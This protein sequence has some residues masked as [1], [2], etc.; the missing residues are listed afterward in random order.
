[1]SSLHLLL[2]FETWQIIWPYVVGIFLVGLILLCVVV[3]IALR[4]SNKN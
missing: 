1:M 4:I 3:I 2:K